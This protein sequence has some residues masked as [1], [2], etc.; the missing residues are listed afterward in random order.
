M[1]K[2]RGYLLKLFALIAIGR[3]GPASNHKLAF[4]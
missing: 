4:L 2:R 1:A 3:A